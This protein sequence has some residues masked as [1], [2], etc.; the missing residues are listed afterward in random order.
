M[1]NESTL[2]A[3]ITDVI[4]YFWL[5][6]EADERSGV[7]RSLEEAKSFKFAWFPVVLQFWKI[8]KLF[9][10]SERIQNLGRNE[11]QL[12]NAVIK[13]K[14]HATKSGFLIK[15]KFEI[16]YNIRH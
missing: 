6:K 4:N 9:T 16:S 3:N 14:K 1:L 15:G 2:R 13:Q 5:L 10:G 8:N 12:F 11:M 7:D